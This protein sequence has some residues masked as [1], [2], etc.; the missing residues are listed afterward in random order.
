M[1]ASAMLPA[2][3]SA[4]TKAATPSRPPSRGS[5][6]P[7]PPPPAQTPQPKLKKKRAAAVKSSP[8]GE[9][10]RAA[11]ALLSADSAAATTPATL[12]D[13]DALAGS[14]PDSQ[15][16][17][18]AAHGETKPEAAPAQLVN[19]VPEHAASLPSVSAASVLTTKP[20]AALH[21]QQRQHQ[22]QQQQEQQQQQRGVQAEQEIDSAVQTAV[23]ACS[24]MNKAG[25]HH[26]SKP[27]TA[28][29]K[30][31]TTAS[32]DRRLALLH[33]GLPT[34]MPNPC[35][36]PPR[37]PS[38]SRRAS[39]PGLSAALPPS[40]LDPQPLSGS[41]S[42]NQVPSSQAMDKVEPAAASQKGA[43]T[44]ALQTGQHTRVTDA[45][46]CIA[47]AAE[48]AGMN[49]SQKSTVMKPSALTE[50]SL[51][52]PSS[53]TSVLPSSGLGDTTYCSFHGLADAYPELYKAAA[54]AGRAEKAS[55]RALQS[56]V[57]ETLKG[58]PDLWRQQ[59]KSA[60]TMCNDRLSHDAVRAPCLTVQR[61]IA[62]SCIMALLAQAPMLAHLKSCMRSSGVLGSLSN[63]SCQR[64]YRWL[65]LEA[66]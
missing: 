48:Q 18:S 36:G 24:D 49:L 39:A 56:F 51:M 65:L 52:K 64:L 19:A 26:A 3:W 63:Q 10:S 22:Q 41:S 46:T 4:S 38:R 17:T 40:A 37:P 55:S 15:M 25:G 29:S 13:A 34:R 33:K 6:A 42:V 8:D 59:L 12:T 27:A 32:F 35:S 62:A 11:A 31:G 16:I 9:S 61:C 43:Q 45:P 30:Q 23:Q 21:S 28:S 66:V 50:G 2:A 7:T 20:D 58:N 47:A 14:T 5:R 57:G 44:V 53:P 60:Y 1:T 54:A